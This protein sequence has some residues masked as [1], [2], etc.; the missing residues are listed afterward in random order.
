MEEMSRCENKFVCNSGL[1]LSR[2]ASPTFIVVIVFNICSQEVR[3]ILIHIEW[4]KAIKHSAFLSRTHSL[5]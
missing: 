1:I 5:Q 3:K 2:D 4:I